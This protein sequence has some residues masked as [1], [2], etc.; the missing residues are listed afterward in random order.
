MPIVAEVYS[1]VVG[2]DTHAAT[3][4]LAVLDARTGAVLDTHTFP[5][6]LPGLS[7]AAAWIARR[8]DGG[9]DAALVAMEGTGSY[10]AP[11]VAVLSRAGYRVVEASQPVRADRRGSG[12]TDAIDAVLAGRGVLGTDTTYLPC[13]RAEGIRSALRVRAVA[14]DQMNQERTRA[15]NTLTALVRTIDIGV[16]ARASLTGAQI[17]QIALRRPR[18]GEDIATATARD[19]ATRLAKRVLTLDEQLAANRAAISELVQALAPQLLKLSGVGPISAAAILIAYSHRGRL[20]SEAAFAKLAGTCPI[21]ASSGNTT[22]HRLNR[23]GDRHL[24]RAIDTITRAR[25]NHDQETRDYVTRRSAEGRTRREIRRCLKR[26]V[27]RQIYRTL[28]SRPLDE[29]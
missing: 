25:M 10:G 7:R 21:P 13:P 20:R 9:P 26:Y 19:E 12:K 2:V 15:I 27:T 28:T 17:R 23:G 24:N 14:R 1:Y 3:H 16:D 6:S 22:R 11:F 5:T 8:C 29:T 4:T 18:S